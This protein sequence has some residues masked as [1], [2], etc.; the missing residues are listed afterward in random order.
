MKFS[1]TT[2]VLFASA[3]SAV[4]TFYFGVYSDPAC[5]VPL[6]GGVDRPHPVTIDASGCDI[7]Q[8][9]SPM[10]GSLRTNAFGRF[11]CEA[12]S[13]TFTHW[14][15][16]YQCESGAKVLTTTLYANK[17][18][19]TQT[20][21][22]ITYQKLLNY[23]VPC[24]SKYDHSSAASSNNM[25]GLS[26]SQ[27]GSQQGNFGGLGGKMG[28]GKIGGRG[29]KM[30]GFGQMGGFSQMGGGKMGGRM[31]GFRQTGQKMNS[32]QMFQAGG[33]LN[34]K[35]GKISG[36]FRGQSGG[37]QYSGSVASYNAGNSAS[38]TSVSNTC[39]RLTD[40][41][42]QLCAS[43]ASHCQTGQKFHQWMVTNCKNTCCQSQTA[44]TVVVPPPIASTQN[45][46]IK[47]D[48][49]PSLCSAY[50]NHC[51]VGKTYSVW[52]SQNCD[53]T[54]C[55]AVSQSCDDLTDKAEAT[56]CSTYS[57][58]CAEGQRWTPWMLQNCAKTCCGSK[59]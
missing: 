20:H 4:E 10:D 26:A 21:M 33:R 38:S 30:G 46:N 22:G 51:Q 53:H 34:Q 37:N 25:F 1:L 45:C 52:M 43:Y 36:G 23:N 59:K 15:Q 31:G 14:P 7:I 40:Q 42:P 12:D 54:C 58:H 44:T 16:S 28:G 8:Y 48:K 19:A 39:A 3:S 55:R 56:M 11:H 9:T 57:S 5:T 35:G 13:V 24:S 2:L 6:R 41:N 49:N 29:G 27:Q 17:C 47:T 18:V 50:A 32:T